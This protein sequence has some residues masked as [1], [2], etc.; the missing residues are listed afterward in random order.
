MLVVEDKPLLVEIPGNTGNIMRTCA[1]TGAH[2]HFGVANGFYN[3]YSVSRS[4]V[5]IPPGF[6]NSYGWR[7]YS[8][9]DMYKG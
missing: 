9:Y 2:L 6:P 1:G 4:N 3:G 8:R 5:L 7:F